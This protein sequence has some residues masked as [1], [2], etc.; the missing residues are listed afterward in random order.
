MSPEIRAWLNVQHLWIQEAAFR[1][2]TNG[3]IT[4][5]DV[6]QLADLIETPPAA[7]HAAKA[8]PN[9]GAGHS[10]QVAK[11]DSI[12]DVIGIDKLHPRIPLTFGPSNLTVVYGSNGS[13]K[14][15]YV[16]IIKKSTGKAGAADLRS[17]VYKTAP[18]TQKC[19]INYSIGTTQK[20][21]DWIAKASI[22]GA[23]PKS[24]TKGR[25]EGVGS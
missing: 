24:E 6:Q 15:G 11:L 18:A 8:Y 21:S 20:S 4:P 25:A 23:K 5:A 10:A 22:K 12:S 1:F 14:S 17:N 19:K 2:L 7:T 3:Q 13:G 16:R 9:I